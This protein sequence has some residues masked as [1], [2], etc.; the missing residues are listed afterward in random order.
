MFTSFIRTN[1]DHVEMNLETGGFEDRKNLLPTEKALYR[2][3]QTQW[4]VDH[5]RDDLAL[6][7]TAYRGGYIKDLDRDRVSKLAAQLDF[8]FDWNLESKSST[9][10][11]GRLDYPKTLRQAQAGALLNRYGQRATIFILDK[12]RKSPSRVAE[13][14]RLAELFQYPPCVTCKLSYRATCSV[15]AIPAQW[16]SSAKPLRRCSL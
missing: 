10:E 11:S 13:G 6:E 7:L 14:T 12:A 8:P 9:D 1:W 3:T 4:M 15:P 2:M 16:F 5:L